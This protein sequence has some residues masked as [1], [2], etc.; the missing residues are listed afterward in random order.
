MLYAFVKLRS[1]FTTTTNKLFLG[2]ESLQ[3]I[4]DTQDDIQ[5][6]GF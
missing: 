3:T 6:R 1:M 4:N 2:S 5:N